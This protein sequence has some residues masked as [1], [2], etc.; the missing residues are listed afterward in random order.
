MTSIIDDNLDTMQ[1]IYS[2]YFSLGHITDDISDKC[3]LICLICYI[4][5]KIKKLKPT[6]DYYD[7][8]KQLAKGYLN[9]LEIKGLTAVC[10]D[11]A[12]GCTKFSNFGIEDKKIPEQIKAML[13]NR[14]PF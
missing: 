9:D 8:I 13:A 2:K 1:I 4:T 12:Y 7:V 14:S 3:G 5:E 11:F 6:I 10:T